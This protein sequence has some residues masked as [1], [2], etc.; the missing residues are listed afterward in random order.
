[1]AATTYAA[2]PDARLFARPGTNA[3]Q[4]EAGL[5]H[6]GIR[7]TRDS[8]LYVPS[9]VAEASKPAPFLLYLHGATGSAELGIKRLRPFADSFGFILLCPS[10]ADYTWDAIRGS[11]DKD[12]RTIDAALTKAFTLCNVD[13]QRL[14][15]C[16][17]SDGASYALGLGLGNGDLFPSV[18][19]WS[20]G[21]VP[22]GFE[23][24][25]KPRVFM[26]HG[27]KDPILP[28]DTCSRVLVP[29]LKR[30][31]YAVTYREFEGVH[32]LP[33]EVSDE[34]YRWFLE[35]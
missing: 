8:Q 31:G 24:Q 32:T 18:M 29:D 25:G 35:P 22:A 9:K 15:V 4:S 5:R 16:G 34:A 20:P 33:K 14:G 1:M 28:I 30:R 26:S 23:R 11:Y 2:R 19:A 3:A 27:T 21:F 7:K 17:F 12:V 6:L 13:L 10:S